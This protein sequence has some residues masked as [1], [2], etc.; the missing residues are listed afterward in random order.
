[1]KTIIFIAFAVSASICLFF[2]GVSYQ[3]RMTARVNSA[4]VHVG[5]H[6]PDS[7]WCQTPDATCNDMGGSGCCPTKP[8]TIWCS[9]S[10]NYSA[11]WPARE[12]GICYAE[13][14]RRKRQ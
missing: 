1:M 7:E 14:A 10:P 13:D 6:G 5:D 12:D 11:F 9:E 2:M 3:E 8:D 4:R